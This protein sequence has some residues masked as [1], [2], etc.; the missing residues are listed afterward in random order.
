MEIIGLI[1]T[2]IY[3][4]WL[5]RLI[6]FGVR[7]ATQINVNTA[8]TAA[9]MA[10]LVEAL[11]PETKERMNQERLARA[12]EENQK[13]ENGYNKPPPRM[14]TKGLG[15]AVTFA[16]V[17][18]AIMACLLILGAVSAR[19]AESTVQRDAP[20]TR[21]YDSRGNST[22]SA[23]RYGDQIKLYDQRGNL[24]GTISS[25]KDCGGCRR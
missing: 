4:I 8:L 17:V 7:T 12:R 6:S 11:S 19:S 13:L 23:S 20:T 9:H 22:G 18:V 1:L 21:F 3:V 5:S 14:N 10:T 2:I 24:V 25:Q 16:G 15:F